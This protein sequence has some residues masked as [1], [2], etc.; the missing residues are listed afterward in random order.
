MSSHTA[1]RPVCA[2]PPFQ[3][4]LSDVLFQCLVI[5]SLPTLRDLTFKPISHYLKTNSSR[6][7]RRSRFEGHSR[8]THSSGNTTHLEWG[9]PSWAEQPLA[10]CISLKASRTWMSAS[11]AVTYEAPQPNCFSVARTSPRSCH[12][13]SCANMCGLGAAQ[14]RDSPSSALL[15]LCRHRAKFWTGNSVWQ[16][17][18]LGRYGSPE[19]WSSCRPDPETHTRFQGRS[20]AI[21][22]TPIK[23]SRAAPASHIFALSRCSPR[24]TA[25]AFL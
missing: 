23:Q 18:L 4:N 12:F 1:C 21:P 10:S 25:R 14:L 5:I 11:P 22:V 20:C 15:L 13:A 7:G 19:S 8:R 6:G 9:S 2:Y 16:I 3:N 17:G 24:V